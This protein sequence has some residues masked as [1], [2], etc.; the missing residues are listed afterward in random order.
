MKKCLVTRIAFVLLLGLCCF[1]GT[2]LAQETEGH[3]FGK[4]PAI[5]AVIHDEQQKSL[6]LDDKDF[7]MEIWFKPLARLKYKPIIMPYVAP[8]CLISKKCYERL[9]G[10]DLSYLNDGSISLTLCDEKTELE[11]ELSFIVPDAVKEN[12]WNCIAV[13]YSH[14]DKKLAFYKDGKVLREFSDVDIGNLS[15]KEPFCISYSTYNPSAQA[16][17]MIREARIWKFSGGLPADVQTA[18]ADHNSNPSKVSDSL[19]KAA[20]Y[21][22]W[23]FTSSND[24]VKDE[25]N[26]GNALCYVPIGYKGGPAIK[27]FPEKAEGAVYYVDNKNPAASDSAEGTKD[28]PF[29]TIMRGA[30]AAKPGDVLRV[31]AGLYRE[32]VL[33]RAGENGKP[34]TMEGEEGTVITGS[35]PLGGWQRTDNGLWIVKNW[36]GSYQPPIDPKTDDARAQPQ[37]LLF[38]DDQPMDFVMTKA[39]LVPGSWTLEPIEGKGSK[40]ITLSP[41]P[42]VDPTK[43]AVEISEVRGGALLVTTRF[44]HVKGIHFTRSSVTVR[45]IGNILENCTVDWTAAG[46]LNYGGQD[47]VMRNIK[48]YWCGL[49]GFG[50][51]GG[52]RNTLENSKISYCCWRKFQ[53]SWHG[54]AVKII[55]SCLDFIMR[56]NE[57]SYNYVSGIWY[58]SANEGNLT[59]RNIIHDNAGGLFDEFNFANTWQD[60]LVYNVIGPGISPANSSEDKVFRNISF[61]NS[62]TPL[63]FRTDTL[64]TTNPEDKRKAEEEETM[65]K[66]DVRRYQGMIPYEREK[67]YRDLLYK[68]W[69]YYIGNGNMRNEIKE[70]VLINQGLLV[71]QPYTYGGADSVAREFGHT[72]SRNYYWSDTPD[73]MIQ[74]GSKGPV[75][76]KTWQSLSGQDKDSQLI[77]PW[78]SRDKMPEWFKERF[79]FGKDEFRPVGEVWDKYIE[80]KIGRSIAQ[81]VLFSRLLRSKTIEEIKFADPDLSGLYFDSEGQK[82]SA[83]WCKGS[84]VKDFIIADSKQVTVENKFLQRKQVEAQ[85]GR[86]SLYVSKDPITL[87]GIGQEIKEDRSVTVTLPRWTEPGKPVAG[88][89]ALENVDQSNKEFDIN[90]NVGSGWVISNGKINKTLAQGEKAEVALEIMPPADVSTGMFQLNITGVVGGRSMN[91][92]K[93]F[94]IGSTGAIKHTGYL[95]IDGDLSDWGKEPPAGIADK[96]EQ[97][98]Y[99]KENW[100]GPDN[101]SAKVWL[102]WNEG[103]ELYFAVDVT[104]DKVVTNHRNDDATK[105]D[106]VQLLV[107]VRAPWKQ[108][109]KDY[110]LGAFKIILVPGTEASEATAIYEGQPFGSITKVASKKTEHGYT[111]EIQVH[112]R[113]NLVEEPGWTEGR[114][115]RVGVLANDSDEPNGGDRKSA[116]GVWRTALDADKDCSSLRTIKLEK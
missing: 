97:V 42:G 111:M 69:C 3:H 7:L 45:G 114:E 70:N 26:N 87:I 95:K 91:Q 9:P 103:R 44:N 58:D 71:S 85:E 72:F 101:L 108:Y 40:A 51:G 49:T 29:K 94:G 60:N 20:N 116:M 65:G 28:K 37:N 67:K 41:L 50:G 21:S 61:N 89:I 105:S 80:G 48:M 73:R 16:N 24:D 79:K 27:P 82:C 32:A 56:N 43:V 75:D 18:I 47:N 38:V 76:L 88:R 64:G 2:V 59:E 31:C 6:N 90:V 17:C 66:W 83:L 77:D 63:F 102:K 4:W 109:M 93:N 8:N 112:F 106:S 23:T 13:C 5:N 15:N 33:L 57:I 84:A 92:T 52:I 14:K 46:G 36:A 39:E 62:F 86:I 55:P 11:K 22:K 110:T 99:G 30:K 113:S 10:Y 19:A 78:Q 107:D 96:A 54:G 12:E 98:V 81:V 104:D 100:K 53:G 34:V 1:P 115:I 74:N 25:G 35:D 68:Y